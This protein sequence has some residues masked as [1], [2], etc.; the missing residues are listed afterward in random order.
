MGR[1]KNPR[2]SLALFPERRPSHDRA[3][4]LVERIPIGSRLRLHMV[5][6]NGPYWYAHTPVRNGKPSKKRYVGSDQKKHE[7][8]QAWEIVAGK[9]AEATA[10]VET[11]PQVRALRDLEM[12]AGRP[13]IARASADD[14]T[15]SAHI[16]V[17][18]GRGRPKK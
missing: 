15:D 12:L 3:F 16:R 1:P 6:E 17:A 7:L 2:P 10:K 14:E 9:L 18:N 11:L 8:E 13:S 4:A 5:K